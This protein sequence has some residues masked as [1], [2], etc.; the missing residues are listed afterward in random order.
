MAKHI[1]RMAEYAQGIN[2]ED[3]SGPDLTP[4][5][6]GRSSNDELQDLTDSFNNM[7]G[8]LKAPMLN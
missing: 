2:L 6:K 1:K 7:K 8:N 4:D 3:L 5:R